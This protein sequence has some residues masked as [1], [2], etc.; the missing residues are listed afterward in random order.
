MN[1]NAKKGGKLTPRQER[2]V[3]EYIIDLNATQAAIRAGYAA[4]DA[5]VQ[6]PRL[7][8][9]VGVSRAVASLKAKRAAETGIT[10]ERVLAELAL[11]AFS[12][13]THFEVDGKG[14]VTLAKGAPAGA[15][16]AVSSIK[17]KISS[18][19][20]GADADGDGPIVQAE[21][22]IKLWD[23]PGMLRLAGRHVGLFP[24]R[25]ELT[26]KDGVPL[27]S[28]AARVTFVLP[29]NGRRVTPAVAEAPKKPKR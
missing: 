18:I 27:E 14:A 25:M 29:D 15:H 12:D 9:N 24:D 7:L 11:L 19:G 8:G 17:R 6:G 2:F 5:D 1:G 20:M 21:V 4:K 23:K 16:R 26:G 3:E 10:A 28:N 13:H 22:E